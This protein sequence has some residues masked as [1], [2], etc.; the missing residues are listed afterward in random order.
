MG[1]AEATG[2]GRGSLYGAFGDKRSLFRKALARYRDT[3]MQQSLAALEQ[4]QAGRAEI[5][6]L[7]MHLAQEAVR[8]AERRGCLATNCSMELAERDPDL[9]HEAAR[10][11][12]RYERAFAQA[13]RQAQARGEIAAGRDPARL[14]RFLTVVMEGMLV[15][16]RAKPDAGWLQDSVAEVAALL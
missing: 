15:L 11:L 2:L 4:P 13:V 1:R 6:A 7:F 12:E 5:L 14:A 3:A 16:A 8:D 10:C 9:A